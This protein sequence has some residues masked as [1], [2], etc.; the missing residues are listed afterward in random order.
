[1]PRRKKEKP[2]QFQPRKFR[3]Y[4]YTLEPRRA[5]EEIKEKQ[6]PPMQPINGKFPDSVEEWRI[7]V[8][9]W[10]LEIPFVFQMRITDVL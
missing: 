7:A 4:Q 6:D 2:F 5:E 3:I 9:L 1:M 8:A 10:K